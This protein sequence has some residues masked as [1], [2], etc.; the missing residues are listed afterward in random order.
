MHYDKKRFLSA[1]V[2][3]YKMAGRHSNIAP[4][5]AAMK[6]E[7]LDLEPSVP[8]SK[9]VYLGCGQREVLP[10]RALIGEKLESF[11]RICFGGPSGKVEGDLCELQEP[12][13]DTTS[14]KKSKK[15]PKH[16]PQQPA[17]PLENGQSGKAR[18]SAKRPEPQVKAYSYE[19][20][21]HIEQA[22]DK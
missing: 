2:D 18:A 13:V 12:S 6:A 20:R 11:K 3:D 5:W 22:V 1:Y 10:D 16:N 14:K 8:L 9:N 21:G 7:G 15:K 4:M 19:T 17:I